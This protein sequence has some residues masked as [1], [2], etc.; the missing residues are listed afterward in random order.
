VT[1]SVHDGHGF[2]PGWYAVTVLFAWC[3]H[4]MTHYC[5]EYFDL[6]ADRAN[7]TP[8]SWTGGSRVLVDGLLDPVVSLSASFVLLFG[9][10]VLIA[11]MP[12]T[13]ARVV[14]VAILAFA[15]FYTAPPL[16]LN[17]HALG[18]ITCAS[19]L[20]ALGPMLAFLLQAGELSPLLLTCVTVMFV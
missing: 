4:L 10:V 9:G 2:S 16:R 14:A 7:D 6:E 17:Y 3:A 13:T 11:V 8:T 5:N 12:A 18:E 19:V 1:V 15:W 20:Y